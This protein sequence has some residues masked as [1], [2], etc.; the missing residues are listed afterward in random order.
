[1]A[2]NLA[3]IDRRAVKLSLP[4]A[5]NM[6]LKWLGSVEGK[7]YLSSGL[8]PLTDSERQMIEHQRSDIEGE[9]ALI[10]GDDE[11]K[12]TLLAKMLMTLAGG[13]TDAMTVRAKQEAYSIAL[14]DTPAW[15]VEQAIAQWY[16]GKVRALKISSSEY[17][18]PPAP[19]VLAIICRSILQ[20]YHDA[21]AKIDDVLT[22]KPL[23]EILKQLHRGAA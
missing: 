19:G 18:W 1:M 13:A 5:V 11:R 21:I 15:V 22:A 10:D 3:T 20:P 23:D 7:K 12:I 6:R 14:I 8:D 17:Q 9:L 2:Q 16:G 4:E